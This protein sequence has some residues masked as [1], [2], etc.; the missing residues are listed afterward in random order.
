MYGVG[1]CRCYP[2]IEKAPIPYSYNYA[3]SRARSPSTLV[4]ECRPEYSHTADWHTPSDETS[5]CPGLPVY[6]DLIPGNIPAIPGV[7][8]DRP[9]TSMCCSKKRATAYRSC[10]GSTLPSPFSWANQR[11]PRGASG[12]AKNRNT[13]NENNSGLVRTHRQ[14]SCSLLDTIARK[15]QESRERHHQLLTSHHHR[16]YYRHHPS[17]GPSCWNPSRQA[18]L[19]AERRSSCEAVEDVTKNTSGETSQN[20]RQQNQVALSLSRRASAASS[21]SYTDQPPSYEDAMKE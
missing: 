19:A 1:S 9:S 15:M 4:A 2:D 20:Q 11:T 6:Q 10:S 17:S 21:A 7:N 16:Y 5:K 14:A 12:W 13:S 3:N 18:S 8:N